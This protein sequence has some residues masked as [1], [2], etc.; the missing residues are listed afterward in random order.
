MGAG[1]GGIAPN[2]ARA[3]RQQTHAHRGR[4]IRV[5]VSV[6]T[7]GDIHVVLGPR[8]LSMHRGDRVEL[9][10]AREQLGELPPRKKGKAE[11][12]R[13]RPLAVD[14]SGRTA[15]TTDGERGLVQASLTGGLTQRLPWQVA[16]LAPVDHQRVLMAHVTGTKARALTSVVVGVPPADPKGKWE[17]EFEADKP[18]KVEWPDNLLWEKAIWSRKSRWT[19]DFDMLEADCNPHGVAIYDTDSAV[20]GLLRPDPTGFASLLRTPK[21]K[22]STV[23]ASATPEGLLVATGL[24]SARRSALVHFDEQGRV[25]RQRTL[26]LAELG[27][28]TVAGDRIICVVEQREVAIFGLLD[29]EERARV[30]LPAELPPSQVVLRAANTTFLLA[31]GDI[32]YQGQ[33]RD[34]AWTI[35][36]FDLSRVPESDAKGPIP[37]A[38]VAPPEP[39]KTPA[40]KA[41]DLGQRIIAQ[42]PQL[43]LD[44]H[45]ANEAWHFKIKEEF[46]I[47]I[48]AVS[49]GGPAETG[50][51]VEV[52]GEG[53]DKRLVEFLDVSVTGVTQVTTRF[54]QRGKTLRAVMPEFLVPAGIEPPKDKKIKPLERFAENPED[55]FLTVRLRGRALEL[56]NN[57]LLYV[58]VGFDRAGTEGSLMRG[59]PL[60]VSEKGPP[61]PAPK[62]EPVAQPAE[63]DIPID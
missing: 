22:D 31:A 20:V 45:Q 53:L 18:K 44:P 19:T 42:A 24:P 52:N 38:E 14:P 4:D 2:P 59:R 41:I 13:L 61:P 43:G 50:L 35:T 36:S 15:F 30:R 29:L 5:P 3:A 56:G 7:N 54:E 55:T 37:L 23:A 49:V 27:P 9:V 39:A 40:Q 16:V 47:E 32:L 26:E 60:T 6:W 33:E 28:L 46:E 48:K 12:A 34:G 10:L 51:Y 62:P 17:R 63:P 57:A 58:R 1:T 21:D 25:I 11:L 8:G